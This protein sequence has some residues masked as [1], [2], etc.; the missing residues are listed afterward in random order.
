VV[1]TPGSV[2]EPLSVT[3]EAGRETILE[4]RNPDSRTHTLTVNEL[5]L[6]MVARAGETVRLPVLPQRTGSFVM[7]CSVP[8]HRAAGHQGRLI[9]R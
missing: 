8:G 9:V 3:L 7:Y 4:L 5:S 2:Y 1:A 6:Q